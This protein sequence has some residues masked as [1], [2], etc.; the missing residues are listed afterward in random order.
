MADSQPL[1][2][3]FHAAIAVEK[4]MADENAM[5]FIE[6][7]VEDVIMCYLSLMD[8]FDHEKLKTAF[9]HVMSRFS[10]KIQPY[11]VD[12]VQHLK[13]QYVRSTRYIDIGGRN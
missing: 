9:E 5:K 7:G 10:N 11:I 4:I 8:Q 1:P 6:L 12:I 2:V 13:K 3:R